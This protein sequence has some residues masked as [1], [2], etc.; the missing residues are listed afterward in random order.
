MISCISIDNKWQNVSF[1]FVAFAF[2]MFVVTNVTALAFFICAGLVAKYLFPVPNDGEHLI[3]RSTL[4]TFSARYMHS[5]FRMAYSA[6]YVYVALS[7]G[8][9][10][11]IDVLFFII[12]FYGYLML[13]YSDF[14]VPNDGKFHGAE[15]SIATVGM[16]FSIVLAVLFTVFLYKSVESF[17]LISVII[18]YPM[19]LL[20]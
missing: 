20:R 8:N 3:S 14:F 4:S 1:V 18:K 13:W 6:T 17:S 2:S 7:F 11:S 10:I 19:T 5:A 15:A 16:I 12:W 9:S